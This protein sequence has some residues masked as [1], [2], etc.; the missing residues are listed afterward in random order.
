MFNPK[1][2]TNTNFDTGSKTGPVADAKSIQETVDYLA[3]R[4]AWDEYVT[5]KSQDPD[6]QYG[7]APATP[8][9]TALDKVIEYKG[10]FEKFTAEEQRFLRALRKGHLIYSDVLHVLIDHHDDIAAGQDL[11]TKYPLLHQAIPSRYDTPNKV[12]E[13]LI[14]IIK[15]YQ[16]QLEHFSEKHAKAIDEALIKHAQS[17]GQE[18]PAIADSETAH[19]G[20]DNWCESE[21][22]ALHTPSEEEAGDEENP[23]SDSFFARLKSRLFKA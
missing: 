11:F 5:L 15:D 13:V 6:Y 8:A 20:S 18:A 3:L 21:D 9:W 22:G 10:K 16:W 23:T 2:G 7:D 19:G 12:I 1:F 4:A 17:I 14:E